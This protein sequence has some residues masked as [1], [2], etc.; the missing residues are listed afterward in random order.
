MW[1]YLR[2]HA[3]RHPRGFFTAGAAAVLL[4]GC[5]GH[6]DRVHVLG[7]NYDRASSSAITLSV[8][9]EQFPSAVVVSDGKP[10]SALRLHEMR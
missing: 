1:D 2:L 8:L 9:H 5:S 3:W 6:P 4:V 10:A 7:R